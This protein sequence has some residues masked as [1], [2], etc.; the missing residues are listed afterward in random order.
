MGL[1]FW[2]ITFLC[3]QYCGFGKLL[4]YVLFNTHK[5]FFIVFNIKSMSPFYLVQVM[6]PVGQKNKK[7]V[8]S[9]TFV[10]IYM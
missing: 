10:L 1:I 2:C 7:I 9:Q 5:Y 8:T 3:H 6:K 4:K